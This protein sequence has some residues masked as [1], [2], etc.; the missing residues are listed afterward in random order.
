[1][2]VAVTFSVWLIVS[3]LNQFQMPAVKKL[4]RKDYFGLIP[5]WTFFAPNPARSDYHLYY[6]DQLPGGSLTP[7]SELNS[8]G[9]RRLIVSVWNP[10]KRRQKAISDFM[11]SLSRTYRNL[12]SDPETLQLSLPY[13]GLLHYVSNADGHASE[14]VATQFAVLQTFGF[15]TTRAPRTVLHSGLHGLP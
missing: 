8:P 11:R 10:G 2:T 15:H 14:A 7:W 1:M 6:R 4:K 9:E 5:R 12:G 13:I 3:A